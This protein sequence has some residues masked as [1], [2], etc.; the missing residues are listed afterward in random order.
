MGEMTP[1]ETEI[2]KFV[3][4]PGHYPDYARHAI[5]AVLDLLDKERAAV[6]AEREIVDLADHALR[7]LLRYGYDEDDWCWC[8]THKMGVG[9]SPGCKAAAQ[10]M[11]AI[12]ARGQA[13]IFTRKAS[14][15]AK[16]TVDRP[17]TKGTTRGKAADNQ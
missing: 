16:A 15:F 13:S 8:E 12:R 11:A 10:A 9:H 17:G 1:R 2:R 14:T 7:E 5:L 6:Q 4:I 3:A